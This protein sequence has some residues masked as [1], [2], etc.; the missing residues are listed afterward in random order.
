MIEIANPEVRP[1]LTYNRIFLRSFVLIQD[2]VTGVR[3][4]EMVIKTFAQDSAGKPVYSDSEQIVAID[5]FDAWMIP[6][7][8]EKLGSVEAVG[9]AYEAAKS[10]SNSLTIV[11]AMAAFQAGVA[12]ICAA[13]GLFDV[14]S[15]A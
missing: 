4:L 15:V 6:V 3:R 1:A 12:Q 9:A 2:P 13:R 7:M 14:Q 8:A 10:A 11:D 5:D